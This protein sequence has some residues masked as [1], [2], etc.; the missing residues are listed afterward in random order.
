MAW[1]EGALA[2]P[3]LPTQNTEV[4]QLMS[5]VYSFQPMPKQHT[6]GTRKSGWVLASFIRDAFLA[7]FLDPV[8]PVLSLVVL[9]PNSQFCY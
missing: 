1:G 6:E 5:S 3:R 7:W 9:N 8:T 4:P 2:G